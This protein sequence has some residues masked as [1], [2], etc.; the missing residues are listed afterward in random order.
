M[1]FHRHHHWR[2][3]GA[4][5]YSARMQ[6]WLQTSKELVLQT[7]IFKLFNVGFKS[8]Q[9]KEGKF[10]VIEP[11]DWINIIPVTKQ[12]Q[13]IMVRQFRFG[14]NEIS[15]E[16][17]AGQ[18]EPGDTPLATASRELAEETGA[19][20]E[21]IMELGKCRPNPAITNNWCHL[22]AAEGVEITKSQTLDPFEEIEVELVP[23]EK[24]E[25]MIAGGE[26]SHA[27]SIACW[28]FYRQH[29]S[30]SL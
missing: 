22:F 9:G 8:P 29:P 30:I 27:L 20:A 28:H 5:I 3:S 1:N 10:T 11:K 12:K 17:P 7:N 18:I 13:V 6:K 16:F 25:Q 4:L 26:I 2:L 23:L 14:S 24:I 19:S 15:L 21:N